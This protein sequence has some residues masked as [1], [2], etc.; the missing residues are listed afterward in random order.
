MT[1]RRARACR[2]GPAAPELERD[3]VVLADGDVLFA[4]P[5]LE[6]VVRA[7]APNAFLGEPEFMDTGEEINLYR[8]GE[9]VVAIRRG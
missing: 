4:P 5:L 7:A 9:R 6:R 1:S 2:S 3:D 8:A